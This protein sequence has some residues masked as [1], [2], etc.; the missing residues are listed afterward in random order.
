[1]EIPHTLNVIRPHGDAVQGTRNHSNGGLRP[2]RNIRCPKSKIYLLKKKKNEQEVPLK[3]C[4]SLLKLLLK[5]EK[6][7]FCRKFSFL[8]FTLFFLFFFFSKGKSPGH[9]SCDKISSRG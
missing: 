3:I 9:Y 1:M 7:D 8:N 4:Y 6:K 2:L 5:K